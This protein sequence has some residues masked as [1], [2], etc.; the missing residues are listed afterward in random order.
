MALT[1]IKTSGIADNAIT[2]A[3]MADDAIDSADF[4]DGSI[5][6]VHLAGSIAVSKT[7][8]S[9]G[10]G[11]TLST[12]S[13]SVDA[14]QSGQITSVG[15][16]TGLTIDASD[17]ILKLKS[18]GDGDAN[19]GYVS[20]ESDNGTSEGWIGYGSTSDSAFKLYLPS[21][22]DHIEFLPNATSAF[23][24]TSTSATFAGDVKVGGSDATLGLQIE[25][26]QSSATTTKITSN[27][28]YTNTSAL[29]HLCVDGDANANQLVLKGDGNVGIGTASPV[30][31]L[32]VKMDTDKHLGITDS[33]SETGDCPTIVAANTAHSA[34]VD[35]GFR[36]DNI[37]FATG[38]SERLRIDS[39]GNVGIGETSPSGKVH[40][41]NGSGITLPTIEASNRNMLILEGDNSENYLVLATPNTASAGIT[42]ADP[43]FKASGSIY[44]FHNDNYMRFATAG[45]ERMKIDNAGN[46]GIGNAATS[47]SNVLTVQD[48]GS[49]GLVKIYSTTGAV[50]DGQAV[51]EVRADDTS[52]PSSYN[53]IDANVG[54]TTKFKVDGDGQMTVVG[55]VMLATQRKLYLD[56]GGNTYIEESSADNIK[57]SVGAN[58]GFW[59]S[60]QFNVTG[61]GVFS[62]SISKGSGSFKIDHPL[63]SK[64]DTHYLVHSFTESPRA[65][66]IYRDKVTLVNGSATVN[67]DTVAGMTEGTFVLL[68]DNVQCFTSNESDWKAVKG[69]V[70]G[71]ILTIECEDSSSTADISWMV[72]GDRKDQ[73]IMD[74]DWTDENGKPIIEPEKENA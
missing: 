50:T 63:P 16:L 66:L 41:V 40:I 62:G 34:L 38:S 33:Q 12:N 3:K 1:K 51:L 2:N 14:D 31:D 69:S 27:P 39:S 35:L 26:D 46:V 42:F 28:T 60:T 65:D 21:G 17:P 30:Y 11:L 64:K 45:T 74:T 24:L 48:S 59:S 18:D 47:P 49:S 32:E 4:A 23:T 9:A 53:L 6:N 19:T 44:Y 68:C 58:G 73:H 61:N 8:L 67:L 55:N 72:V 5:D 57:F 20:W 43:E 36:G 13:L 70:S 29:M 10:A 37:I 7:L 15:S 71:N 52:S 25:Y 54:G 56:G 22:N